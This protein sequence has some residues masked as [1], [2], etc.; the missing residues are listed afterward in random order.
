MAAERTF[1]MEA[2]RKNEV[3]RRKNSGPSLRCYY[4]TL[5]GSLN[6]HLTRR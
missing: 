4:K 6:F 5:K 3:A 2:L 1:E